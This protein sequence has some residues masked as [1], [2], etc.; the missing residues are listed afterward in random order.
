MPVQ[1]TN[2]K[3]ITYT[4]FRGTTK[5][6]KARYNFVRDAADRCAVD[7]IPEGWEIRESV[8]GI[9]SLARKQA[10]KHRPEEITIVEEAVHDH[11]KARNYRVNVKQ[12]RIE[13]YETI[14]PDVDDLFS[15]LK[16]LGFPVQDKREA[17]QETLE[18]NAQFTPV[19]RFTL[20][21]EE[22]RTYRVERWC[23]SSSIDGWLFINTGPLEALARRTIP[24][25][26][27]DAFFE[28]F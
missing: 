23:Y 7:E 10:Q 4:L 21:D 19:L 3:G 22:T 17:L 6:G 27:T 25:L 2:R 9:V 20:T 26:G 13:V 5:T 8:N 24:T 14:G 12:D 18:R 16:E 15:D 11:P 28:L 1:Y